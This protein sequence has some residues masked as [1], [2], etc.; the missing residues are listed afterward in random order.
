MVILYES[1]ESVSAVT[2]KVGLDAIEMQRNLDFLEES[3]AVVNKPMAKCKESIYI[4]DI[5]SLVP[6]TGDFLD[7][8]DPKESSPDLDASITTSALTGDYFDDGNLSITRE[9]EFMTFLRLIEKLANCIRRLDKKILEEKGKSAILLE[10][11][12]ML[13]FE[14]ATLGDKIKEE[15]RVG[16]EEQREVVE[17]A[18]S[19]G[20]EVDFLLMTEGSTKSEM[21]PSTLEDIKW[22][23][24]EKSR[25][26]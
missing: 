6:G 26:Q 9:P 20:R 14:N 17:H 22:K 10:Q 18:T 25:M 23:A 4:F 11:N 8:E 15:S 24:I 2:L 13:K 21:A 5:D 16:I 7:E 1:M 3:G 12:C 19:P